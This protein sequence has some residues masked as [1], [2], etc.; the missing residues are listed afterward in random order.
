MVSIVQNLS[1]PSSWWLTED[2]LR[3]GFTGSVGPTDS[4]THIH[5]ICTENAWAPRGRRS[6]G[7]WDQLQA[8]AYSPAFYYEL[9]VLYAPH[10][11]FKAL[12][13]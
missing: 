8:S 9:P 13:P 6:T 2:G 3:F 11:S 5:S 12:Q 1:F 7:P 10:L 4:G